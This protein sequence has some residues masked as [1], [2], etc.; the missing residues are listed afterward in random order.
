MGFVRN[1]NWETIAYLI[2]YGVTQGENKIFERAQIM[3]PDTLDLSIKFLK[4]IGHKENPTSP[5]QTLQRT[6]QN[7]R[8]KGFIDFLDKR[9]SYKLTRRGYNEM[10]S[11]V[12]D[13]R[14]ELNRIKPNSG[15]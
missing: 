10:L 6:L 2:I 14:D 15:V 9:G 8:D 12:D 13:F 1:S 5:E 4:D 3:S 7:L 11:V